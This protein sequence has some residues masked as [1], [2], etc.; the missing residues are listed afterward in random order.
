MQSIVEANKMNTCTCTARHNIGSMK[1]QVSTTVNS[2][3]DKCINRMSRSV[4]STDAHGGVSLTDRFRDDQSS[5][6]LWVWGFVVS[7]GLWEGQRLGVQQSILAVKKL[8]N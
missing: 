2:T 3:S 6:G 8:S 1:L 7:E 4:H 5:G